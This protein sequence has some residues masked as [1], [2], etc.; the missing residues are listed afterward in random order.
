M[1]RS[2][3]K[4]GDGDTQTDRDG[5]EFNG[6]FGRYRVAVGSKSSIVFSRKT[7]GRRET[8]RPT[9][10][11]GTLQTPSEPSSDQNRNQ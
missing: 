11:Q 3:E 10:N 2:L 5:P 6:P 9:W 1:C 7:R 4:R 8:M